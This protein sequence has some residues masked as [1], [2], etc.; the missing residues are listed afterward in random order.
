MISAV[1]RTLSA[2]ISVSELSVGRLSGILSLGVHPNRIVVNAWASVRKRN[3]NL[4]LMFRR[5]SCVLSCVRGRTNDFRLPTPPSAS[6]GSPLLGP[7]ALRFLWAGQLPAVL[8]LSTTG[9]K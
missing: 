4:V 8:R 2:T 5:T 7:E 1:T 6:G 9:R 3:Q